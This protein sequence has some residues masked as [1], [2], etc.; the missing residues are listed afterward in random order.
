VI[1]TMLLFLKPHYRRIE[2]GFPVHYGSAGEEQE[3]EEINTEEIERKAR[4]RK[5]RRRALQ[6]LLEK[7]V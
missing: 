5:R 3:L 4:R 6:I 7:I 2:S 1:C